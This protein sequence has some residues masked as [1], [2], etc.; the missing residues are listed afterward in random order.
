VDGAF[1]AAAGTGGDGHR[2]GRR[3]ERG[4]QGH[5]SGHRGGF[6]RAVERQFQREA[7]A[8]PGLALDRDVAAHPPCQVARDGEAQAG[9]AELAAGAAVGLPERFEDDGQLVRRNADAGIAHGEADAAGRVRFHAKRDPAGLGELERVGDQVLQDLQQPLRVTDHLR[10]RARRDLGSE[11]QALLARQRVEGLAQALQHR[12]QRHRVVG[13]LDV[14]G[15]DLG[16]VEDVVD[17]RKQ[18]AVGIVDRPGVL[19]LLLGQ[20]AVLVVGQQPGQDQRAVQRRAQLVRHVRQ[21][22]GLVAAGGLQRAG[23]AHQFRLRLEQR[24]LLAFQLP[25]AFLQPH[26][27]LL[28]LGLLGFEAGLGVLERAAL[29]LQLLVG[30]AQ[31]LLLRLQF[32]AL[33]AGFLQQFRL[34]L[35]QQRGTQGDADDLA[36]LLEQGQVL[37]VAVGALQ[38]AQLQRAQRHAVGDD[39]R[40]QQFGRSA[41][42]ERGGYRQ[43]VGRQGGHAAHLAELQRLAELAGVVPQLARLAV[44]EGHAAGQQ[45]AAAF[46]PVQRADFG[47][48]LLAQAAHGVGGQRF[49]R[50]LAG[51][52]AGQRVLALLQPQQALGVAAR[53]DGHVH[54]EGDDPDGDGADAAVEHDDDGFAAGR[55]KLRAQGEQRRGEGGRGEGHRGLRLEQGQR[56]AEEIQAPDRVAGRDERADAEGGDEQEGDEDVDDAFAQCCLGHHGVR[57][58][59]LIRAGRSARGRPMPVAGRCPRARAGDPDQATVGPV[60]SQGSSR[61]GRRKRP[62]AESSVPLRCQP[63]RKRHGLPAIALVLLIGFFVGRLFGGD[64]GALWGS[65]SVSCRAWPARPPSRSR[66][67]DTGPTTGARSADGG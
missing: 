51:Q 35:A 52:R 39:R 42:T 55:R 21:E 54:D 49:G 45:Q 30:D 50:L 13:Q 10:G 58:E 40:Q 12:G 26:V 32:L 62:G 24:L 11:G 29:L 53:P 65:A 56:D 46:E 31:L 1:A 2:R 61:P 7:A 27:G 3:F 43:V 36:G 28:Q 5:R 16:Q 4:G 47:V 67:G 6:R 38:A 19:H 8:A 59:G 17:Q 37:P 60:R 20:V 44:V 18:V 15:L 14:P 66:C 63:G 41:A 23:V 34:V 33:P 25:G 9:A 57:A 64:A 22:F 48:E